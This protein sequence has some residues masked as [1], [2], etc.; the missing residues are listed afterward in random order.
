MIEMWWKKLFFPGRKHVTT[1]RISYT[2]D[3]L[4]VAAFGILWIGGLVLW[5]VYSG[6]SIGRCWCSDSWCPSSCGIA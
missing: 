4:L 2:W 1:R 6:R 3:S 5:G